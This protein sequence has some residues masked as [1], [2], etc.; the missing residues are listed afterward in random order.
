MWCWK[1]KERQIKTPDLKPVEQRDSNYT[2]EKLSN[3]L[4][5]MYETL[6]I[7][8]MG[9]QKRSHVSWCVLMSKRNRVEYE[10]VSAMLRANLVLD[11]DWRIIAA[12]HAMEAGFDLKKGIHNGQRWD[13]KTTLVPKGRGPF[14]SF[15][16]SCLDAFQIKELPPV[17]DVPNTLNFAERF[18]GIGYRRKG[19]NSPYLWAYSNY[20]EPGKYVRDHVFDPNAISLQVGFAVILKQLHFK[21]S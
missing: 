21:D 2:P 6:E 16:S 7:E 17:F 5:R 3:N 13:R 20:Q 15:A 12:L 19:K 14:V 11:I 4:K 1:R 18:N 8:T 9:R 10:A